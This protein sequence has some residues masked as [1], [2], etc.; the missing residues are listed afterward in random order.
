MEALV[1]V[2]AR[3]HFRKLATGVNVS[4]L[5]PLMIKVDATVATMKM[6]PQITARL[7]KVTA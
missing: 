7:H 5:V 1:I 4:P 2:F 3:L 6:I